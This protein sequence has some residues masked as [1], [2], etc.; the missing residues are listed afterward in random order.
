MPYLSPVSVFPARACASTCVWIDIRTW[1]PSA[2]P[3]LGC[4][5]RTV[6]SSQLSFDVSGKVRVP[7]CSGESY[8]P[9]LPPV[10]YFVSLRKQVSTSHSSPNY[11][12]FPH[13]NL[14]PAYISGTPQSCILQRVRVCHCR[15]PRTQNRCIVSTARCNLWFSLTVLTRKIR[16]LIE[17]RRT[18]ADRRPEASKPE[19][20]PSRNAAAL[21]PA[22]TPASGESRHSRGGIGVD[23]P[24]AKILS[25]RTADRTPENKPRE[26][27]PPPRAIYVPAVPQYRNLLSLG[28]VTVEA[29]SLY[30]YRRSTHG[31]PFIH[32][33]SPVSIHNKP[34]LEP[35]VSVVSDAAVHHTWSKPK[36]CEI[37]APRCADARGGEH[38]AGCA[39]G[40]LPGARAGGA[41]RLSGRCEIVET[42][43]G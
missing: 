16:R 25:Y 34:L 30:S 1:H 11:M 27:T 21:R 32:S 8:H 43:A 28:I 33:R 7:S 3:A 31:E 9:A 10:P 5:P 6:T 41:S 29:R 24:P 15:A 20:L 22:P 13:P 23:D 17:D 39:G 12:I 35:C 14:L 4:G 37:V 26:A 18:E 36:F 42:V 38:A 40:P 2:P 19:K